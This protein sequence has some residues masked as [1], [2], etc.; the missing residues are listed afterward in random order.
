MNC[1]ECGSRIEVVGFV[2]ESIDERP[3]VRWCVNCG[4]LHIENGVRR[5]PTSKDLKD[6]LKLDAEVREATTLLY[7]LQQENA[8][9][10]EVGA[11]KERGAVLAKLLAVLELQGKAFDSAEVVSMLK[12]LVA[13]VTER[14]KVLAP[15]WPERLAEEN[16]ELKEA[17]KD[18]M[19]DLFDYIDSLA[20][21]GV[22]PPTDALYLKVDAFEKRL[23]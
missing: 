7:D 19:D 8:E 4:S 13:W 5:S 23:E 1:F 10:I 3:L 2:R 6:R 18:I 9:P 12:A 15:F 14:G 20:S 22:D 21:K 11:A 17:A 16:R